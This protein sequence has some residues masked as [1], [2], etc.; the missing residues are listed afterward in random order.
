PSLSRRSLLLR[1]ERSVSAVRPRDDESLLRGLA[2]WARPDSAGDLRSALWRRRSA[3]GARPG[4]ALSEAPDQSPAFDVYSGVSSLCGY[5]HRALW[6]LARR[7]A[8]ES[9]PFT[10]GSLR[11]RSVPRRAL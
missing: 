11:C 4:F 5:V 9:A 1:G 7:Q 2:V 3:A 8:M 6:R 10:R